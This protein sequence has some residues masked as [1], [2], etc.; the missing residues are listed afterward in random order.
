MDVDLTRGSSPRMRGTLGG[1]PSTHVDDGIIPAYAGNTQS[2][3]KTKASHS[4]H[5]RVCGEHFNAVRNATSPQGS[6]PRMR[7]TLYDSVRHGFTSRII[8]AYAGNTIHP[9]GY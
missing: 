2:D 8:P 3:S 1:L 9:I 4:D 6:S 7:G 5:P